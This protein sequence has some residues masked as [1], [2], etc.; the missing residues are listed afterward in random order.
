[1]RRQMKVQGVAMAVAQHM[2][3]GRESPAGTSQGMI[4]G[5]LGIALLAASA[6][7][8]G[9]ADHGAVNAP[10][11]AIDQA[12]VDAGGPQSGEDRVERTIAIP[13]IEEIPDGGPRAE[14][15]GKIA[16]RGACPQDPEDA[17]EDLAPVSPRSARAS[18]WRE[19]VFH[20]FPL[21]VRKSMAQHP[22][23]P[24]WCACPYTQFWRAGQ[25]SPGKSRFSDIA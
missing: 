12:Q 5:F 13:G 8:S 22:A 3:L 15:P 16:P 23:M 6:G 11:L 24:P 14:F 20:E 7:A 9:G 21:W 1:P 18:R 17:V 19:E 2:H 25:W 10:Q 4:R